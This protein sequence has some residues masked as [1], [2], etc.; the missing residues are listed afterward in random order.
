MDEETPNNRLNSAGGDTSQTQPFLYKTDGDKAFA[1]YESAEGAKFLPNSLF[2]EGGLPQNSVDGLFNYFIA[3]RK[4]PAKSY[5]FY[6]NSETKDF[7]DE[8]TPFVSRNPTANQI[9]TTIMKGEGPGIPPYL[10]KESVF[11]GQPYN[12]KDFIFCKN[13]GTIPN[14][15]MITLRRFPH[16]VDDHLSISNEAEMKA[17][18]DKVSIEKSG[19]SSLTVQQFLN[20]VGQPIAQCVGYFG[21]GT[22]NDLNSIIKF[23]NGLNWKQETQE[24]MLKSQG[25]DP[26]LMNTFFGGAIG[27][28]LGSN[29]QQFLSTV[30]DLVGSAATPDRQRFAFERAV[31][32]KL[33]T[34]D[35]LLSKKIFVDVNTVDKMW[36]R[37]VGFSG[38]DESFTLKFSYEL[39]SVSTINSRMLFMDL[40]SNLLQIG[41]DY[42]KF[43]A[44]EIR[45]NSS[46]QGINFPGGSQGYAEFL[47]EPIEYF[48]KMISGAYSDQMTKLLDTAG[49]NLQ[50]IMTQVGNLSQEN[51]G[52]FLGS[53][54]KNSISYKFLENFLRSE[55]IKN[56][57]FKPM[58]LSGFPTGSWHLVVGNPLNPI[59]MMGNLICKSVSIDFGEVLGPD[60]FPTEMTATYALTPARQRHRGDYE[61][62]FNRGRGRFY[63]GTL[64][65]EGETKNWVINTAGA[66]VL[67]TNGQNPVETLQNIVNNNDQQ[68]GST[69][70]GTNT[71]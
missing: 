55:A 65:Q 2:Y 46:L 48:K 34:S 41:T 44:P 1:T 18:A 3:G 43:L 57:G 21:P 31:F 61:S 17:A 63:L 30:S 12:V 45:H 7:V 15:R 24:T 28:A 71:Q 42:G 5:T 52:T 67:D 9:M 56:I 54:D 69:V 16:P 59:A 47:T 62:M 36:R 27:A 60:D 11:R 6:M 53:M 58:F 13:Y 14:N 8:V 29:T 22:G 35:T 26:G 66:V 49:K 33:Y 32:D 51:L 19:A 64:K 10:Q 50:E 23:T 20:G 39:T 37:E 38:G 68:T 70:S 25:N 40:F 4:D